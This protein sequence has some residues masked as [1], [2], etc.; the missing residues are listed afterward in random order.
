M[1]EINYKD[2]SVEELQEKFVSERANLQQLKMTHAVSVLE[3][4]IQIRN[5]RRAIAQI[6]TELQN[7]KSQA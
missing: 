6:K 1:A 5:S 3:S 7:R 4:P 2:L